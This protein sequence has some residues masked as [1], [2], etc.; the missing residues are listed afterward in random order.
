[1][2]QLCAPPLARHPVSLRPHQGVPVK[3]YVYIT[4]RGHFSAAHRLENPAWSIEKNME[5]FGK[6]ASPNYHGHNFYIEV[7][8][9]GE[10]DPDTGMVV[11]FSDLKRIVD[12][13][14][15][16]QVDHKNLNLDVPFLRGVNPTAE[17]LVVKFWEQ[18]APHFP[19][20]MLYK[21][22]LYETAKNVV[23]YYGP[24]ED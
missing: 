14:L 10:V 4:R 15:I 22:T 23:E 6:C 24:S 1:M 13:H 12:R 7:T 9:R 20:G 11:D 8:L 17:N 18:L 3:R 16:D 19:S 2:Q 21:I 5:V